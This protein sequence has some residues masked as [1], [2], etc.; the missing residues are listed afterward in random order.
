MK[1]VFAVVMGLIL[2]CLASGSAAKAPQ[3]WMPVAN[4]DANRS[5]LTWR[6]IGSTWTD[7]GKTQGP[8]C[9]NAGS[10]GTAPRL[11]RV[12]VRCRRTKCIDW[13][14]ERSPSSLPVLASAQ[15][16]DHDAV[17]ERQTAS[18]MSKLGRYIT[19]REQFSAGSRCACQRSYSRVMPP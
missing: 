6:S 12:H 1:G 14:S 13:Q 16:V 19:A 18:G 9:Y 17:S 10:K 11:H 7:L 15:E 5:R 4:R 3:R 2:L 8:S